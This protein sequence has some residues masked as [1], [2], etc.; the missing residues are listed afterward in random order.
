[1][2]TSP[3]FDARL[4]SRTLESIYRVYS[5][6]SELYFIHL[7]GLGA[8][9][10][11]VTVHFGL[12]GILIGSALKKRAQRQTEAILQNAENKDPESLVRENK[13]SFKV[14]VPEISEAVL[15]PPALFQMHGQQAGRWSFKLR[16]G[17]KFQF[18]FETADAMKAAL[19]TLPG[20]L[21]AT[22]RVN[23]EWNESKKKF[24]KKQA[25]Y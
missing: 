16:D 22:L 21:N 15:E 20:L 4:V 18:E 25:P 19:D 1:M 2:Q 6:G 9:T 24:E 13:H 5:Q 8:M 12:L 7:G 10:Q 23:A 14:Y 17:K 11:A 3:L